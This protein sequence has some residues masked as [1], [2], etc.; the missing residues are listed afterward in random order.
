[1]PSPAKLKLIVI[2]ILEIFRVHI[3]IGRINLVEGFHVGYSFQ[4]IVPISR[5]YPAVSLGRLTMLGCDDRGGVRSP[6]GH[7]P[8]TVI[9]DVVGRVGRV[10][11]LVP[12]G[13]QQTRSALGSVPQKHA[14]GPP[15]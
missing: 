3:S 6:G 13:S 12:D 7:V 4:D 1:M 11:A 5:V 8:H 2:I 10:P 14:A 15:A 9:L